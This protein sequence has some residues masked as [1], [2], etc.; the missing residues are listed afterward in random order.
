M[1][2]AVV[3]DF[4]KDY[5]LFLK[6]FYQSELVKKLILRNFY[7]KICCLVEGDEGSC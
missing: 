3:T 6:T 7:E 1:V 2:S 4:Q 5:N